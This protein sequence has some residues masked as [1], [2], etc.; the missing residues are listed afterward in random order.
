MGRPEPG[1]RRAD[2]DGEEQ[3]EHQRAHEHPGDHS[4]WPEV[5]LGGF[6]T[7]ERADTGEEERRTTAKAPRWIGEIEGARSTSGGVAAELGGGV[8]GGYV[9]E[10]ARDA[11]ERRRERGKL[12]VSEEG[13]SAIALT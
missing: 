11:R 4:A 8:H 6:A 12:S 1:W 13:A 7:Y 9:Q 3:R 10:R 2:D 5:A